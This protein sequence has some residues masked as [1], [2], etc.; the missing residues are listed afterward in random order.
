LNRLD[1]V[2]FHYITHTE[3]LVS[4]FHQGILCHQSAQPLRPRSVASPE[5]QTRRAARVVPRGMPLHHYANVYFTA[6]NPMMYVLASQHEELAVIQLSPGILDLPGAI[7]A[8]GNAASDP[9]AFWPSPQG[10]T[11]LDA[12][13]IFAEFWKDRNDNEFEQKRKKRI[14]CA[15]LLVPDLIPPEFMSGV[16]VSCAETERVVMGLNLS[17]PIT[18]NPHVFFRA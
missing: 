12:E 16:C 15:E 18:Q 10:L 8:D 1:I 7:I 11:R 17:V 2:E 5:V 4:I 14:K 13:A 9:T 6:R 3:N